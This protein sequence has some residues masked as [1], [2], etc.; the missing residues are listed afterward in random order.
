MGH[1][2]SPHILTNMLTVHLKVTYMYCSKK[3][4]F[5]HQK[6]SSYSYELRLLAQ[7]L[8][9]S[10]TKCQLT[11]MLL[12]FSTE[13][14]SHFWLAKYVHPDLVP[15]RTLIHWSLKTFVLIYWVLE[16]QVLSL[17]LKTAAALLNT[18]KE[19]KEKAKGQ[20]KHR[21]KQYNCHR[22]EIPVL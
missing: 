15:H 19:T 17:C 22:K 11:A 13:H 1:W 2:S 9:M 5:Y 8:E 10:V 18:F 16:R 14:T 21:R 20:L 12:C 6:R 7:H 4:G 3:H